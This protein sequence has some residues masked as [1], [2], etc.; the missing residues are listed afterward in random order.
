MQTGSTETVAA[1]EKEVE[2]VPEFDDVEL[3]AALGFQL[4]TSSA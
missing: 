2:E 4:A 3:A 1:V